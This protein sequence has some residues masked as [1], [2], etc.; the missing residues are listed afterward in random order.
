MVRK[1]QDTNNN[2]EMLT[3]ILRA[4]VYELYL[5]IYLWKNN[6]V[7]NFFYRFLYFPMKAVP[8]ISKNCLLIIS[9]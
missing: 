6:K 2:K 8:K 9:L 4:L 1:K 3:N 7:I 5:E